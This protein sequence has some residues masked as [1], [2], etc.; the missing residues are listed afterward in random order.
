MPILNVSYTKN[1]KIFPKN[2]NHD[3]CYSKHMIMRDRLIDG[4]KSLR[5]SGA[6]YFVIWAGYSSCS[7]NSQVGHCYFTLNLN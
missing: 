1:I 4:V 7:S 3:S 6:K 5:S 2:V